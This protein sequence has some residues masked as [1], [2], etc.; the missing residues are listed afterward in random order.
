MSSDYQPILEGG[1]VTLRPLP[2][3]D[4]DALYA[5]SADPLIWEQHPDKTRLRPRVSRSSFVRR[6]PLVVP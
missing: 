3:A 2:A 6:W 4:Y 1:R 5:V